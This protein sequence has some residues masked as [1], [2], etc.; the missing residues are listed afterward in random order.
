MANVNY[1]DADL[2]RLYKRLGNRVINESKKKK[3][4]SLE[5]EDFTLVALSEGF[6]IEP[7]GLL[8]HRLFGITSYLEIGE[9]GLHKGHFSRRNPFRPYI[10]R[11]L[12]EF[13]K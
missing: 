5:R 4:H 12:P 3:I 9:I 10:L 8:T 2:Y 7:R 11:D 1:A 6:T 13:A